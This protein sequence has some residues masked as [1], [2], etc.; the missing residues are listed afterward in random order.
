MPDL[1]R[2]KDY[3]VRLG[4]ASL[5]FYMFLLG[6]FAAYEVE[7]LGGVNIADFPA[8]PFVVCLGCAHRVLFCRGPDAL[9]HLVPLPATCPACFPRC[10]LDGCRDEVNGRGGWLRSFRHRCRCRSG[11]MLAE[12]V[13]GLPDRSAQD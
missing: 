10:L 7:T 12:G 1:V 8:V 6:S 5:D 2:G 11:R 3:L 9:V 13:Q 4:A